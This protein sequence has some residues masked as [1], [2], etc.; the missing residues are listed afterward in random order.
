MV[1]AS[2]VVSL[3]SEESDMDGRLNSKLFIQPASS[4]TGVRVG[5]RLCLLLPS[6]CCADGTVYVTKDCNVSDYSTDILHL[7]RR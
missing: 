6:E 5:G 4:G 3:S 2:K 7:D 1:A